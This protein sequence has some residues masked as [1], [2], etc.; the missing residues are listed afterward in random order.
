[1]IAIDPI[2]RFAGCSASGRLRPSLHPCARD[3]VVFGF[4]QADLVARIGAVLRDERVE[5][6]AQREAGLVELRI[7]REGGERFRAIVEAG[8]AGVA[9]VVTRPG[10]G[11]DGL[12][13]EPTSKS[14]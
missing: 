12:P 11:G 14:S 9:A 13:S 3:R 8:A 5:E 6:F 4:V 2:G 10:G 1:M 7:G